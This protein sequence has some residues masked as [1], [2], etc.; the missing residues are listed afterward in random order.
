M[1]GMAVNSGLEE[2]KAELVHLLEFAAEKS[3]EVGLWIDGKPFDVTLRQIATQLDVPSR[4]TDHSY[5][6]Q[7]RTVARV[8]RSIRRNVR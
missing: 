8:E 1:I 7:E 4:F 6:K 3:I 5:L 2:K